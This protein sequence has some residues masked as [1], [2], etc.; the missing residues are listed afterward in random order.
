MWTTS[1]QNRHEDNYDFTIIN[2]YISK[3]TVGV[4]VEV[5]IRALV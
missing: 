5:G 2:S 3:I 4:V 1:V